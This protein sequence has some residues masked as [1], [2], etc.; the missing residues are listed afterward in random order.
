MKFKWVFPSANVEVSGALLHAAGGRQMLARLL[1]MRGIRDPEAA[2]RFL[3]ANAYQRSE[4]E[5]LTDLMKAAGRLE[6]AVSNREKILVWGD[7]DVDG[8]TSTS[9]LVSALRGLGGEVDFHIPIRA[10]EGHGIRP[11]FLEPFLKRGIDV[12]LSCDTGIAAHEAI[13]LA[14]GYGV[15]VLITDHHDLPQQLP[16]AYALVNPKREPADHPMSGFPGVAVAYVLIEALYT[17]AGRA[18]DLD[19]FLDLVALGIVADV[20]IQTKDTRCLLQHGLEVLRRTRRPGLLALYEIAKVQAA[21]VNDETIGFQIGPRLNAV[22]RLADANVSVELLTTDDVSRARQIAADLEELNLRRRFETETVYES[23]KAQIDRDPSLLQYA[24]LVLAHPEWHQGVIGIVASRL[25]EEF[26]KPAILLSAPDGEAARGSARSIDGYH[27]TEAIAKQSDILHGFGGHPMAAGMAL[28]AEHIERFRR[29]V[30]K[31]IIEQRVGDPPEPAID[32]SAI[33]QL[34]DLTE[35]LAHEIEALAPFGAGNPPVNVLCRGLVI[36]DVKLIGKDQSHRKLFVTDAGG[37]RAE[38]LWWN[39]V[40]DYLPAGPLDVV[41]QIRPGTFNGRPQVTITLQD[42][43]PARAAGDRAGEFGYQ[44]RDFRKMESPAL[45]LKAVRA[46]N[47]ALQVWSEGVTDQVGVRNRMQLEAGPSLALWTL[48]PSPAVLNELVERVR[49]ETIFVFA[50][51]PEFDDPMA[52]FK[53]FIGLIK[54]TL[55]HYNGQT[56]LEKLAAA[57]A[58]DKYAMRSALRILPKLGVAAEIDA[59]EQVHLAPVE[60]VGEMDESGI[61]AVLREAKAFRRA[62]AQASALDSFF[63]R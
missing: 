60:P 25:V 12:L 8:Q 19:E 47:P 61:Q 21:S 14:N 63:I 22:G 42:L 54:Y 23:A 20:A 43:D 24:A 4:P 11:E 28:D 36:E 50:R 16:A 26:G 6:Q 3:D 13:D 49:P 57:C 29:G 45:H 7:F 56:T 10:T 46:E 48:P 41:V 18:G 39:S 55:Q 40:D 58:H 35:E 51:D 9:L 32:I 59:D 5:G 15:D 44:I 53:R 33:L 1:A 34:S 38:V 37:G 2:V 30:S 27:I 62:F 31:A 52:F 17:R